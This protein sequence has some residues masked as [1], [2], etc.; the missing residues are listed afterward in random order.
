MM[1]SFMMIRPVACSILLCVFS[2]YMHPSAHANSVPLEKVRESVYVVGIV[3]A[4]DG[5]FNNIGTAWT[6]DHGYLASN[7]HVAEALVEAKGPRDRMVAKQGFFDRNEIVL[8]EPIIH[9]AYEVW[10]QRI[11]RMIRRTASGMETFDAQPVAD[12][13]LLPVVVGDAGDPLPVAAGNAYRALLGDEVYYVGFPSETISGF[14]TL[15]VVPMR[16]TAATDFFFRPNDWSEEGLLHLSGQ[17]SGGASGSPVVRSDGSVIG[18]LSS[19]DF[20]MGITSG[21]NLGRVSVGFTYAQKVD[22][23]VELKDGTAPARQQARDLAWQRDIR[24]GIFATPNEMLINAAHSHAR[25]LHNARLAQI[26]EVTQQAWNFNTRVNSRSLRLRLE[27]GY[28]YYFAAV[29]DDGTDIDSRVRVGDQVLGQDEMDDHWPL[30]D[31]IAREGQT[32]AIYEV[33]A[34]EP[35]FGQLEVTTRVYRHPVDENALS[36]R[37][38]FERNFDLIEELGTE[39]H[40]EEFVT[41]RHGAMVHR[42]V[43]R[44]EAGHMYSAYAVSRRRRDVD[45][46]ASQFEEVLAVDEE[47]DHYPIVS[48][49]PEPGPVELELIIPSASREG[50]IIEL[51]IY[52]IPL[53]DETLQRLEEVRATTEG[54]SLNPAATPEYGETTLSAGFTADPHEVTMVAGGE[55]HVTPLQLGTDC[56]GYA[57]IAPDYVLNW[58]G[59]SAR[60]RV[61]FKAQ[62]QNADTTLIVQTPNGAW[63]GNDDSQSGNLNPLVTLAGHG[64]GRYAI[65]VGTYADGEF[66]AGTLSITELNLSP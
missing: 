23:A 63:V 37:E 47:Y 61:F 59:D 53:T 35:V 16:V 20:V 38:Q 33:Y 27:P 34:V 11:G 10:N 49:T 41:P 40:R 57:A 42:H 25:D 52:E 31:I 64:P 56:T 9:P 8:G 39:I 45:L 18:I 44:S 7:A 65:W 26:E 30:V 4:E 60:L 22:L 5:T 36:S 15:H 6:I 46:R 43:L 58:E 50:E 24:Q 48:L 3:S 12:V 54:G 51:A 13:A 2:L 1:H 32:D 17:T 29:A 14:A 19:G 55:V 28:S 66:H 62:E 21:E